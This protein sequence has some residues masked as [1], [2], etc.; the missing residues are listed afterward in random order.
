MDYHLSS[1]ICFLLYW[2]DAFHLYGDL[3]LVIPVDLRCQRPHLPKV[4][5]LPV[6][7]PGLEYQ[8]L[9][10]LGRCLFNI[11]NDTPQLVVKTSTLGIQ[12][13]Y[14]FPSSTGFLVLYQ[15]LDGPTFTLGHPLPILSCLALIKCDCI[16]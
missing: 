11:H 9:R 12:P 14:L 6:T 16:P 10:C 4:I 2:E 5:H 7:K 3:T 8:F 13:T 15:I 1:Y